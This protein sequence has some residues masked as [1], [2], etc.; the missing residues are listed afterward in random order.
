MS[1]LT[2]M[3]RH[4]WLVFA[5]WVWVV[6]ALAYFGSFLATL[7][8][9]WARPVD[10]SDLITG[11]S[12]AS[13]R[14]GLV[15]LGLSV[16]GYI[17]ITHGLNS[18]LPI[19]YFLLGLVIFLRRSDDWVAILAA[20]LFVMFLGNPFTKLAQTYPGWATAG[21][22]T[23]GVSSTL[24]ILLFYVFPDGRFTPRWMR[25]LFL[26]MVGIQLWRVFRPEQY[27]QAA[28]IIVAPFYASIILTQ[29]Y[30]Y[31]RIAG[32]VQR[33]QIKWVVAGLVGGLVP[34]VLWLLLFNIS[35]QLRQPTALSVGFSLIGNLLWTA[36]L[37]VLPVCFT[38]AI[39]RSHL[40][41]IDIL[42]R[43]TLAYGLITGFLALVYFGSVLLLQGVFQAI[44][45]RYQS[46]I[47]TVISTL[48][49]AALFNP[50]RQRVQEFIDRRFYRRKYDAEHS[51]AQFAAIARNEVD[52]E[53]LT[54][55]L[56][57]TV[58]QAV[59]PEKI[60]LWVPRSRGSTE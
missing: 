33:Q 54:T 15:Q 19:I 48:V 40:W 27:Q 47:A 50:L 7:P 23:D 56:L 43:S 58:K 14:A 26:S 42:I 29:V 4:R 6:L 46:P 39:L 51:L 8:L 25:W 2:V 52:Q 44:T 34:L 18:L 35:P 16:E 3:P 28:L 37:I 57:G 36:L 12:D 49:I 21:E 59:Q 60:S 10:L 24:F 31:L 9:T 17:A 22:I 11:W 20:T 53:K 55:A 41:D 32:P 30:R 13:V 5:R 38:I 45:G 1:I